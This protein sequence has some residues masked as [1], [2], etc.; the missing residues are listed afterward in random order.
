M[1][2]FHDNP[3]FFGTLDDFLVLVR[4]RR[5]PL[6]RE[7]A[8]VDGV[9][10]HFLDVFRAPTVSVWIDGRNSEPFFSSLGRCGDSAFRKYRCDMLL[11]HARGSHLENLSH[12]GRG[13]FVNNK[14]NAV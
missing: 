7:V 13:L 5:R 10:K 14:G 1:R 12:D 2:I 9:R 8:D 4:Y 3:I 11:S 6:L